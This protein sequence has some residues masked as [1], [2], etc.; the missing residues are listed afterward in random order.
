MGWCDLT[1]RRPRQG[2]QR[3]GTCGY[4]LSVAPDEAADLHRGISSKA[5]HTVSGCLATGPGGSP[6]HYKG[7][8]QSFSN[9]LLRA[10]MTKNV[11]S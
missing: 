10:W 6:L 3:P 11:S 5:G 2:L 4:H 7:I 1:P 9:Q 8:T